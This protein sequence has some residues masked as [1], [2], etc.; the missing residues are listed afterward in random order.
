MFE[1]YGTD[2][3]FCGCETIEFDGQ[4]PGPIPKNGRIIDHLKPLSRGGSRTKLSNLR[5][6]CFGCN[7][8]KADSEWGDEEA[9][10]PATLADVWPLQGQ[11]LQDAG[12]SQRPSDADEP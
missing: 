2:C 7:S 12:C 3:F 11:H 9:Y 5:P 8:V 6:S 1:L 10:K 4:A